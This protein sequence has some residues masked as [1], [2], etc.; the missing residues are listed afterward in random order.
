MAIEFINPN[1]P[2]YISYAWIED[3]NDVLE[4][5]RVMR[6]NGID[7]R[8]DKDGL[9]PIQTNLAEIEKKIGD[10]DAVIVI[11]SRKYMTSLHT[12]N[13]WHNILFKGD[14]GRRVFVVVLDDAGI[15]NYDTFQECRGVLDEHFKK[16]DDRFQ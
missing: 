8:R 16:L 13:E 9:C 15:S 11:I 12:M 2:V 3:N 6:E 4:I 10:G 5:C 7:Y 14:I 1:N